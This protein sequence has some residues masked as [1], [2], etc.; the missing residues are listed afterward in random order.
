MAEKRTGTPRRAE[1]SVILAM[2]ERIDKAEQQARAA[3]E[4]I[5]HYRGLLEDTR[6]MLQTHLITCAASSSRM[7]S[8]QES[9]EKGVSELN[10][11]LSAL[12]GRFFHIIIA[13]AG[14]A[15]CSLLAVA[16]M[17]VQSFIK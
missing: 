13:V 11:G 7:E 2:K 1:D 5:A 16:A 8:R 14:G 9:I 3:S 10:T 12:N 17:V 15:I 4:G 6:A